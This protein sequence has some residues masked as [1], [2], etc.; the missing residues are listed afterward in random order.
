[1]PMEFYRKPPNT[2]PRVRRAHNVCPPLVQ[3]LRGPQG[4]ASSGPASN[5]DRHTFFC[6]RMPMRPASRPCPWNSFRQINKSAAG[7]PPSGVAF[8][9]RSLP[10][11]GRIFPAASQFCARL[12]R[13]LQCRVSRP[14]FSGRNRTGGS[15]SRSGGWWQLPA[16]L[17]GIGDGG[18]HATGTHPQLYVAHGQPGEPLVWLEQPFRDQH[19]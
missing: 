13:Q 16:Q 18:W 19:P 9:A 7:R 8:T 5:Q 12:R 10:R 6:W 3:Q 14:A 11:H 17:S 4:S 1:M 2:R 15:A